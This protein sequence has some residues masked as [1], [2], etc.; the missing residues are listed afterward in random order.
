M[1]SSNFLKLFEYCIFPPIK[2]SVRLSPHQFGYRKNTSTILTTALLKETV[3]NYL[4]DFNPV[5]SAFLDL[6]K[7]FERVD[8][9]ILIHKLL[10]LIHI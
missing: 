7:A 4:N 10:S 8:H 9:D 3:N 6:S 1:I 2:H 5:Y